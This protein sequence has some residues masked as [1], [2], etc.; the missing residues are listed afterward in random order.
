MNFFFKRHLA[1]WLKTNLDSSS[2]AVIAIGGAPVTV[3]FDSCCNFWRFWYTRCPNEGLLCLLP[4]YGSLWWVK[5]RA[6]ETG[7]FYAQ[8]DAH[9]IANGWPSARRFAWQQPGS[10]DK[11]TGERRRDASKEQ[12]ALRCLLYVIWHHQRCHHYREPTQYSE[13]GLRPCTNN[14]SVFNMAV[15]HVV[16]RPLSKLLFAMT[17]TTTAA[18]YDVTCGID[19]HMGRDPAQW[20]NAHN[21]VNMKQR[22]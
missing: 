17:S 6:R 1:A 13:A 20:K 9:S 5:A 18:G 11:R 4:L 12:P 7:F 3:I 15:F 16:G 22:N 21:R 2:S 19:D 8:S 10:A 14:S